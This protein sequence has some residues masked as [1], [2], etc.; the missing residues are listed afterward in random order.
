MPYFLL[1]CRVISKVEVVGIISDLRFY[2][3]KTKFLVDDSTGSIQCILFPG[4]T[5]IGLTLGDLVRVHGKLRTFQRDISEAVNEITVENL[6]IEENPNVESL[7][8]L[9]V[10]DNLILY[11]QPFQVPHNQIRKDT[12]SCVLLAYL[13]NNGML[14]FD[15]TLF[16]QPQILK[17]ISEDFGKMIQPVY[18][19]SRE[20]WVDGRQG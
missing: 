6:A 15:G 1:G 10:L 16:Y 19:P 4:T 7:H 14:Q 3:D 2:P 11:S 20:Y 13:E 5:P 18:F 8:W 17:A 9:Q 12:L